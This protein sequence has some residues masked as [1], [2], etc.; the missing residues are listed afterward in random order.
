MEKKWNVYREDADRIS[1]FAG[2]LSIPETL[3][4]LLW[5]RDIRT[6]EAAEA[7]LYPEEKQVFHDPFRMKDMDKAVERILRAIRDHE[8]ITVYGDYDVDG[9]TSTTLLTR[10]LRKLGGRADYYIPERR[11][12]GYGLNPRALQKLVSSGTDLIVSVDCGIASVEDVAAFSGKVDIVITDH[13]IPGQQLP[14]AV[15]VVDPHREDCSYPDKNLAGVGVSFKLCQALW[16]QE[17]QVQFEG[18]AELVALGTI[19]DIVPLLGENRKLVRMG[20]DRLARTEFP[21]IRELIEVSGLLGR[22]I[23]AG[24]VGFMLAP[25]LNAAGRMGSAMDGVR[26]LLA[27]EEDVPLARVL[28]AEL[29][30][31]N[32]QRQQMEREILELAERK[33]SRMDLSKM[34]SIVLDGEDWHPGVIGIVASRLVDKYYLPTIIISRHGNLGKGSCRSIA[35]LHMYDALCAC[36]RYLLGFGGH[37]QAAGL[38]LATDS[39]SDFRRAFDTHV[40]EI[41]Q[42][43]DFCPSVNI[44]FE[45]R[46]QEIDISLV[47]EIARLEP[48]GM[49]NPRPLFGSRGVRGFHARSIGREKQHLAFDLGDPDRRITAVYWNRAS[50]AN[51]VEAEALDIVYSPQVNEWQGRKSV[52]LILEEME[53]AASERIFPERGILVKVYSMLRDMSSDPRGIPLDDCALTDAFA[54][55]FG[56]ISLYTMK[57][58]LRIFQELGLLQPDGAEMRYRLPVPKG[59][60]DLMESA[61]YRKHMG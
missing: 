52:E 60:M 20:L 8:K 61:F 37:S 2:K 49:G 22:D 13:H 3:A 10:N 42:E 46:P 50:Y 12:E 55:H 31:K 6:Q 28:A 44:E 5:H 51:R 15:A 27:G 35:A 43:S 11:E 4:G 58:S 30:E 53:S 40:G 38:T 48:Y 32:T 25:R 26:L 47:E 17:K 36:E 57:C 29:N 41:L 23:G 54:G 1:E 7:F 16:R 21:G 56:H 45:L 33:L 9:I 34:H 19:A 24:Q 18:D 39:I 59:K 14:S